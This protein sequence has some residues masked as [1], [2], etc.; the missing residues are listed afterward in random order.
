MLDNELF[1]LALLKKNK[2]K[3]AEDHTFE[4]AY[5]GGVGTGL[6]YYNDRITELT[7]GAF[8]RAV[9]FDSVILPNV[10]NFVGSGTTSSMFVN[11]SL[12]EIRLPKLTN[13][14]RGSFQNNANL[15][16]LDI[17]FCTNLSLSNNPK[18]NKLILH[19]FC[20]PSGATG[21]NNTPFK[22]DGD[23]GYV[24]VPQS[25]LTQFQN[26]QAWQDYANI[27]EFR[28]IEGSEYELEE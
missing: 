24:Y 23:G 3:D 7:I 21:F 18:L 11:S 25:L 6:S 28:A 8:T 27:L 16:I 9:S 22:K 20:E 17:G 5:L 26:S 19:S 12:R 1:T 2:S 13:L 14:G 4:D 15:E 10:T